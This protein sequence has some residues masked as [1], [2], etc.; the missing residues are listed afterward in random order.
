MGNI[1]I[2]V[3]DNGEPS[4]G[5]SVKVST[6]FLIGVADRNLGEG[7]TNGTGYLEVDY[8]TYSFSV[9]QVKASKLGKSG[10]ASFNTDWLGN[11]TQQSVTIDLSTSEAIEKTVEEAKNA[12]F[13][14]VLATVVVGVVAVVTSLFR[15]AK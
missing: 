11:P 6:K 8:G 13:W 7:T 14:I 2:Y 3:V 10:S 9:I 12:I 1:K 5:A 4:G 15:R